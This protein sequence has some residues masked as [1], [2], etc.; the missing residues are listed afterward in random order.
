MDF[1]FK[2]PAQKTIFSRPSDRLITGFFEVNMRSVGRCKIDV[3]TSE[4]LLQDIY[5][6]SMTSNPFA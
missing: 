2:V 4:R 1:E 3:I 6:R 5:I